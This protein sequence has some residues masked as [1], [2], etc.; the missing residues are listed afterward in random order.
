MKSFDAFVYSIHLK[1]THSQ[2]ARQTLTE[3]SIQKQE[4]IIENKIKSNT[5]NEYS[6]SE[7]KIAVF[8]VQGIPQFVESSSL[9]R[10]EN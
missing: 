9:I 10:I 1:C 3:L 2:E 8:Y 5:K 7:Q 4:K 6:F